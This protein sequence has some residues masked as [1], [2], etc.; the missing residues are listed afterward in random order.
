MD[1]ST[2]YIPPD[3]EISKLI[4]EDPTK[5]DISKTSVR[6][7]MLFLACFLCFGNYFIYDNPS[8]L[9]PQLKKVTFI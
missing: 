3:H 5:P 7:Y 9:A 8:A 1:S 4:P 2:E 6:Y